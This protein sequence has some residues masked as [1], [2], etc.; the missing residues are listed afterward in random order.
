MKLRNFLGKLPFTSKKS[1][2]AHAQEDFYTEDHF[3]IEEAIKTTLSS[4]ETLP[5]NSTQTP[6]KEHFITSPYSLKTASR[7]TSSPKK[8]K[9][10][11]LQK[12]HLGLLF[13]QNKL[14]TAHLTCSPTHVSIDLLTTIQAS[15]DAKPLDILEN[16]L[17]STKIK[18]AL[19]TTGF[20][21]LKTLA[22]PIE[23]DFFK[24][25]ELDALLKYQIEPLLPY[26]ISHAVLDKIK[27]PKPHLQVHNNSSQFLVFSVRKEDLQSHLDG[28]LA[29]NIEPEIISPKSLG[30]MHFAKLFFPD[31]APRIFIDISLDETT[32]ILIQNGFPAAIRSLPMG[33]EQ[34]E[35][36]EQVLNEENEKSSSHLEAF[37][38]ELSRIL[39]S[40]QSTF[41]DLKTM[42]IVFTGV[43][44][45]DPLIL[46][47]L[48]KLLGFRTESLAT[49]P[50]QIRLAEG[51]QLEDCTAFAIP[52]GLALISSPAPSQ[53]ELKEELIN[54]RKEEFTYSRKWRRW[55]KDLLVYLSLMAI[56][57]CCFYVLGMHSLKKEEH[58]VREKYAALLIL[59]EKTPTE[60][61]TVFA[62]KMGLSVVDEGTDLIQTLS[63]ADIQTRL[64]F[65]ESTLL[66]KSYDEIALHP[67]IA[68][69][70]DVLAWL[71]TLTSV[72]SAPSISIDSLAYTMIKRPE[73]EKPKEHYS[74]RI[75]IDFTAP[76]GARAR[77]FYDVLNSP[78]PFVDPKEEIKWSSNKGRYQT[79]F[80][81]KDRT[82]YP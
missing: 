26:D 40:L 30:L 8:V 71:S 67:N 14:F 74:V 5:Q 55:K 65:I 60:L 63:L 31:A 25:A 2:L 68:R 64:N 19:I 21:S 77:E 44:E 51:I 37:A 50:A 16:M 80:L 33:L 22:R 59:L 45:R 52:I 73:K 53:K 3:D 9:E 35:L 10:K 24:P 43:A 58:A 32:C 47:L 1:A 46:S 72:Q 79:S 18:K 56:V 13:E 81:L 75:D 28:Y 54:F 34:Q 39:L 4:E 27:I 69:V 61:E 15:D 57:S 38:R 12:N 66:K 49:L 70:S 29:Q 78:N 17:S 23:I 41:P 36:E 76:N 7:V 6:T 62:K 11:L 20:S 42:P 82:Q 48:G